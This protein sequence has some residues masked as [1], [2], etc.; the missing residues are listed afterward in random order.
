MTRNVRE[1]S[2]KRKWL[3]L[4]FCLLFLLIFWANDS[5]ESYE[6]NDSSGPTSKKKDIVISIQ[7]VEVLLNN[8]AVTNG[9]VLAGDVVPAEGR[10][11]IL[12]DTDLHGW[13]TAN[14]YVLAG[15]AD[16]TA[17]RPD[18]SGKVEKS[19][20]PKS[21]SQPSAGASGKDMDART[22]SR[23]NLHWDV[24]RDA[25]WKMRKDV[26]SRNIKMPTKERLREIG[27]A[28]SVEKFSK[29]ELTVW[30]YYYL[31]IGLEFKN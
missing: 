7:M 31:L 10:V 20:T 6:N 15:D 14:G 25:Y 18:T 30:A 19:T 28:K 5:T 23:K 2:G 22:W 16:V 9:Y 12:V 3:P 11:L 24:N 21:V 1:T 8:W 13:A 27:D 29:N 17:R 26:E 4:M